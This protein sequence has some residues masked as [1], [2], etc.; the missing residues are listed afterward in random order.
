[1]TNEVCQGFCYSKGYI[2]AATEWS[3]ECCCDN[4]YD[5]STVTSPTDCSMACVCSALD[6]CGGSLRHSLFQNIGTPS[7]PS[8]PSTL[9]TFDC[10]TDSVFNR[11]LTYRVY[12]TA[13]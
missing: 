13:Q 7:P 3:N 10:Y 8:T 9:Q 4:S 12:S 1:M 11:A 6:T 5:S 2:Y